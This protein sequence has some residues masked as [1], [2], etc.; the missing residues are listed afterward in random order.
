MANQKKKKTRRS[1]VKHPGLEKRWNSKIKQ[2]YIDYDEKYLEDLNKNPEA[3]EWMNKFSEEYIGAKLNH[4]DPIHDTPKL[5]KDCFDRNNQR[6]R[7][8]LSNVKAGN[9]TEEELQL[10]KHRRANSSDENIEE[11][12]IEYIDSKNEEED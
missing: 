4:E 6:N 8:L 7:C 2:E 5:R 9:K 3:K 1:Q 10:H 11:Y 12:L